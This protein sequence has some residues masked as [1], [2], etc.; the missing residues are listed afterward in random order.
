MKFKP[1]VLATKY[2]RFPDFQL[3]LSIVNPPN[4][5]FCPPEKSDTSDFDEI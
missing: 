3:L 2:G 1:Y 4:R 5:G